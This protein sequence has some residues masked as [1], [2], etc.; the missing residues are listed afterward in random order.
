MG[1]HWCFYCEAHIPHDSPKGRRQ[2]WAG[3]PHKQA[4]NA[5]FSRWLADATGHGQLPPP[6]AGLPQQGRG[7][8]GPAT[9]GGPPPPP[10]PMQ[11]QL[12][13]PMLHD[14]PPSQNKQY[15][16][17]PPHHRQHGPSRG[18]YPPAHGRERAEHLGS[19][20]EGF[21]GGWR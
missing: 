15:D 13:R 3:R 1:G 20:D 10:S 2:H 11:G 4:V 17:Y 16:G 21:R 12:H 19:H 6:W 9:R 18:A 7:D 14:V 8:A 5:F